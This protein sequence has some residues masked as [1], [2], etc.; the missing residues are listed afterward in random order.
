MKHLLRLIYT[1]RATV[2]FDEAAVDDLLVKARRNNYDTGVTGALSFNHGHFL[3][4]LEGPETEV[5]PL[6]ARILH[7]RRHRE[8]VIIAIH[9]IHERL[10]PNWSMGHVRPNPR[11]GS[12]YN[13][14]LDYR[15]VTDN[16]AA[17]QRLLNDLFEIV[18]ES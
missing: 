16:P 4:V 17:T 7:D 1:S 10:F 15:A 12:Q 3:Q 13:E 2:A 11:V 14:L 8:C 18:L 9:L 5:L 6:Y